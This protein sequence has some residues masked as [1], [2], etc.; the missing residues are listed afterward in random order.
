MTDNIVEWL[1]ISLIK[2]SFDNLMYESNPQNANLN[3]FPFY[4]DEILITRQRIY[5]INDDIVEM[6]NT[7]SIVDIYTNRM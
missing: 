2:I 4:G 7:G 5:R 3:G 6:L 1:K